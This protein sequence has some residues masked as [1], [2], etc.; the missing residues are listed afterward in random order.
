MCVCIYEFV[1][2]THT[3][4]SSNQIQQ[5]ITTHTRTQAHT[6]ARMHAYT[7]GVAERA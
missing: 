6:Q 3:P 1:L 7:F 4:E 2:T 5:S